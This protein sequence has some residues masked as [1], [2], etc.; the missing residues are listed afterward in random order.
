MIACSELNKRIELNEYTIYLHVD[1]EDTNNPQIYIEFDWEN[2]NI[3]PIHINLTKESLE[4]ISTIKK[5]INQH[6]NNDEEI[7]VIVEDWI[8]DISEFYNYL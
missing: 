6:T 4:D 2:K 8:E 3:D 5:I 1:D 7:F